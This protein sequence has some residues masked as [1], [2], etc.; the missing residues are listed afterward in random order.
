MTPHRRKLIW[1]L[2]LAAIA[3]VRSTGSSEPQA[4]QVPPANLPVPPRIPRTAVELAL[5]DPLN[6]P[7]MLYL[8]CPAGSDDEFFTACLVANVALLQGTIPYRPD[9][10]CGGALVRVDL[11]QLC[12]TEDQ[13]KRLLHLVRE[14][15]PVYEP[16][17]HLTRRIEVRHGKDTKVETVVTVSPNV[18]SAI[19]VG[20]VFRV[21]QFAWKCLS[22]VDGGIYYELRGLAVGK[23]TLKEYLA[24]R[25]FDYNRALKNN[26]IDQ[27]VTVSQVTS[28]D[29]IIQFG[30]SENGRPAEST[31]IVAITK[32]V[33]RGRNDPDKNAFQSLLNDD[34]KYF[35]EVIVQN[36]AGQQEFTLFDENQM[37]LAAADPEVA[38]DTTVPSPFPRT[39]H[40]A[41]SCINCHGGSEGMKAFTPR[42]SVQ[43]PG[44]T[45]IVADISKRD[46]FATAQAINSRYHASEQQLKALLES[47]RFSLARQYDYLRTV[48]GEHG[49]QLAC[50]ATTAV[51]NRY[52]NSF[53]SPEQ[54]AADLGLTAPKGG[55][56]MDALKSAIPYTPGVATG[57]AG[58]LNQLRDGHEITRADADFIYPEAM[59]M[60]LPAIDKAEQK[61]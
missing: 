41:I 45:R 16:F 39:L 24:S 13:L 55:T 27:T 52:K 48:N 14:V 17:F 58:I 18:D 23:S 25:G 32:D 35:Y 49:Y 38:T 7:T 29:R 54:F 5:A 44:S 51:V 21:D 33:K 43:V 19:G 4:K 12:D 11:A 42:F 46:Q 60:A 20:K 15:A 57:S 26:T 8:W 3:S 6:S 28:E 56:I 47:E 10:I 59:A 31:G 61:Q 37:L 50:E 53:V 40:G 9:R 22:Q 1:L 2:A 34:Q 36:A 30:R